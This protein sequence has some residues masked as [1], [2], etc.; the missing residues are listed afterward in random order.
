MAPEY[1][2]IMGGS[3]DAPPFKY[4]VDLCVQGFIAVRRV[5]PAIMAL[6]SLMQAHP[7]PPPPFLYD[8]NL[9]R[10]LH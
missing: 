2:Q 9:I 3:V 1:I 4:F 7:Q 5:A 10:N 6:A 8:I